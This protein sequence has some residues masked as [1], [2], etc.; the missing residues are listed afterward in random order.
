MTTVAQIRLFC[1]C[2]AIAGELAHTS[3]PPGS[4]A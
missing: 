4:A 3:G 1:H 2:V